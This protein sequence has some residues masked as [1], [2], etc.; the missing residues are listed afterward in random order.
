MSKDLSLFYRFGTRCL[1]QCVQ[2][3]KDGCALLFFSLFSL[4]VLERL[5]EG[6]FT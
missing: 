5:I 6:D 3:S 1:T 4:F 2:E